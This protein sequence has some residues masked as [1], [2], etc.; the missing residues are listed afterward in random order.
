[1]ESVQY[2]SSFYYANETIDYN[3]IY[4]GNNHHQQ[5]RQPNTFSNKFNYL[6]TIFYILF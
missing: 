2:E 3:S 5:Q 6:V 4:N 1:M